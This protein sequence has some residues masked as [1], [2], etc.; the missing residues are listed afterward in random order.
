MSDKLIFKAQTDKGKTQTT[1]KETVK[2]SVI[3]GWY[4]GKLYNGSLT[5][6]VE[7]KKLC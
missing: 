5:T 7:V 1:D 4:I 2:K 3:V 6:K